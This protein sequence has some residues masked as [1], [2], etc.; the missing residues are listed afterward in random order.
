MG[1]VF[2]SGQAL[3][4]SDVQR[5]P[6]FGRS[7]AQQTQYVPRSIVAVPLVDEHGTIGVL[8]V[9]DKRDSSAFSLRDIELAGVFAGQA[10]V[11]IRAT[12]VERESSALLEA[13][14]RLVLGP[15]A[16]DRA[17]ESVVSSATAGMARE[18]PGRL[19]TLVDQVAR[20]RR[21]DPEQVALVT[22]LLGVLADHAER[23]RAG[24]RGPLR[25]R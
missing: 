19:W 2:T 8:E 13:V 20:I 10:A 18:D 4:L 24:R 21:A 25:A 17:V 3:A 1:Y 6:R 12:R 14:V 15:E 5:D 9:L 23:R 7:F 16:D 22:D 11:A